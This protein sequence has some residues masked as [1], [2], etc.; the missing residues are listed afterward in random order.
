MKYLICFF[1]LSIISALLLMD[2]HQ[3]KSKKYALIDFLTAFFEQNVPQNKSLNLFL[4]AMI[5]LTADFVLAEPYRNQEKILSELKSGKTSFLIKSMQQREPFFAKILKNLF[6]GKDVKIK[7]NEAQSKTEKLVLCLFLEANRQRGL[8]E[9]N[10]PSFFINKKYRVLRQFLKAD[11][12]FFKTDMKKASQNLMHCLPYFYKT[13]LIDEAAYAHFMLAQ[14][15]VL[16]KQSDAGEILFQ[17]ALDLYLKNENMYGVATIYMHL[18]SFFGDLNRFDDAKN[19]LQSLKK[20]IKTYNITDLD[21][22]IKKIK[23]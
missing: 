18:T 10:L 7:K 5:D 14:M 22:L 12:L 11:I 3:K 13:G 17:K 20:C 16:A 15:Y 2:K 23:L 4:T 8:I 1:A 21:E 9:A 19:T 6:L